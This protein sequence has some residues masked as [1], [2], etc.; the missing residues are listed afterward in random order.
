MKRPNTYSEWMESFDLLRE[1][2][3]DADVMEC[4]RK[5]TLNLSAGVA[6]RFASQLNAVIQYR[7]KKASEKFD[8]AMKMNS[9]DVNLLSASLLA[10]R[11]EINFLISFVRLPILT[12]EEADILVNAIKEQALSMQKSLENTAKSLDR[13]GMLASTIKKNNIDKFER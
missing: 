12:S 2:K 8:R 1:G 6:E 13:T 9:G 7:I 5:G 11:R 10:L 4:T 3:N